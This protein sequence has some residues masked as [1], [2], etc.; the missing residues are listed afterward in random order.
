M[1]EGHPRAS[2]SKRKEIGGRDIK[3][4]ERQDA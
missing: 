4:K 1:T 3:R 2:T